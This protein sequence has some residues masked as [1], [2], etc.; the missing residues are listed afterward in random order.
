[1]ATA[2]FGDAIVDEVETAVGTEAM[3][4][5]ESESELDSSRDAVEVW[6][7]DLLTELVMIEA[8]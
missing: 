4:V 8:E 5:V 6:D 1:M 2:A 3:L 7:S